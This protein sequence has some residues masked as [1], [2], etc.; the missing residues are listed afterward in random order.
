MIIDF[1]S[2]IYRRGRE[3]S[4][5]KG[6]HGIRDPFKVGNSKGVMLKKCTIPKESGIFRVFLNFD[7]SSTYVVSPDFK[8]EAFLIVLT[9]KSDPCSRIAKTNANISISHTVKFC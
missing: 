7:I 5:A 6:I 4:M 2:E 8:R 1:I 3:G 9:I